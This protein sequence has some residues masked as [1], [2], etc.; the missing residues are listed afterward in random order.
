MDHSSIGG[1]IVAARVA[2]GYA[3]A[4]SFSRVAGMGPSQLWKYEKNR[5]VPGPKLLARIAELTGVTM[6]WLA[7]GKAFEP[8]GC[9]AAA[10]G[11]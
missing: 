2:A 8:S 7:T 10:V 6:Y 5:R 3:S 1:R 9:V 4:S 11:E